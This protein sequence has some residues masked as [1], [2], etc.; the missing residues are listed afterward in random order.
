MITRG[1][2]VK[3]PCTPC[4]PKLVVET[5]GDC[6]CL[7]HKTLCAT[8]LRMECLALQKKKNP[9]ETVMAPCRRHQQEVLM[10]EEGYGK[11]AAVS[12]EKKKSE[13][14]SGDLLAI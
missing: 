11:K 12:V 2:L 13:H 7:F 10:C 3:F 4:I 6:W 8:V 5:G 14:L 9:K 1:A